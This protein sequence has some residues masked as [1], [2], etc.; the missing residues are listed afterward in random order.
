MTGGKVAVIGEKQ[1]VT[2]FKAIGF[3]TFYASTSQATTDIVR[4]LVKDNAY[5]VIFITEDVAKGMDETLAILKS[6][7]YPIVVPLPALESNGYGM[8]CIKKDVE[9]AIGIDILFNKNE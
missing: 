3:D 9:R 8:E 1:V 4:R 5:A 7:S 2:A 6:R